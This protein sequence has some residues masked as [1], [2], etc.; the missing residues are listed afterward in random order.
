MKQKLEALNEANQYIEKLEN[1]IGL[2]IQKIRDNEIEEGNKLLGQISQGLEWLCEIIVLTKSIQCHEINVY[3]LNDI[4]GEIVA[5]MENE[6][7]MTVTEV[8]EYELLNL[9]SIWKK[10]VVDSLEHYN[11]RYVGW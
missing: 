4:I 1:G 10:E 2:A 5:C 6:D 7:F 9:I 3:A 8:L 11:I